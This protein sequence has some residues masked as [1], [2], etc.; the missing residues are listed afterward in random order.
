LEHKKKKLFFYNLNGKCI[1]VQKGSHPKLGKI[2]Q[3]KR[4]KNQ[5]NFL[6]CLDK[7]LILARN[8]TLHGGKPKQED[9]DEEKEKIS[10]TNR[11]AMLCG[12]CLFPEYR[13]CYKCHF[14]LCWK[15][16]QSW[17]FCSICSEPTA[18]YH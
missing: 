8:H 12:L 7:K 10:Y 15:C 18:F 1:H 9:D 11:P 16:S 13:F 5:I 4:K 14:P 6:Y 2:K 17:T 3:E